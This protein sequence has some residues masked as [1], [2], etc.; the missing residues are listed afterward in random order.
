MTTLKFNLL[1]PSQFDG[2]GHSS[3]GGLGL[4]L[5]LQA[6]FASSEE[7]YPP[8]GNIWQLKKIISNPMLL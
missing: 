2:I 4:G 7:I 8:C 5:R 6:P 1:P 3:A